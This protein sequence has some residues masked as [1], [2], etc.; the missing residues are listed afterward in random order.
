MVIT[1]LVDNPRSWIIPFAQTLVK[2][3]QNFKHDVILLHNATDIRSGDCVF[4]LGCEKIIGKE[5]LNK[6]KH[7]LVIHESYLPLGKGWSPLTWQILEGKNEI[8]IT[9]FE[10]E[11]NV[12]SG[13]IYLQ[14]VV[15]FAG[16]EL[17]EEM[18][19][20]QGEKT[21]EL[22]KKFV[23]NYPNFQAKKQVGKESF[24]SR[25]LPV[26]SEVNTDKTIAEQFNLLRVVDNERYP[27]FFNYRGHKYIIKIFPY[28]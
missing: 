4:F 7:N 24:Y 5:I 18:R 27:A 1:I 21:I 22:V 23:N 17:I 6:N 13:D 12:D 10:A 14:E 20:K 16:H 9:L 28:A 25:R 2:D 26:D 19:E 15:H 3:L 11:E 8:P